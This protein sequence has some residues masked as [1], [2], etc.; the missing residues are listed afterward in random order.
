MRV[1]IYFACKGNG[2]FEKIK[3]FIGEEVSS[4][5]LV[6]ITLNGML[7]EYQVFITNLV[8]REKAPSF[9]DL[10]RILMQEEERGRVSTMF[11]SKFQIKL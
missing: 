10:T 4:S 11:I 2:K 5:D 3:K 8:A 1:K 9:D 7:H 6:T